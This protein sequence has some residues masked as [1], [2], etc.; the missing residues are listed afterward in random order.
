ML[1]I[2]RHFSF[3]CK[4]SR[5]CSACVR[6]LVLKRKIRQ[7]PRAVADLY[8]IGC[9]LQARG[10]RDPSVVWLASQTIKSQKVMYFLR[11]KTSQMVR[12]VRLIASCPGVVLSSCWRELVCGEL[13]M[14]PPARLKTV[15]YT[16]GF[17]LPLETRT[18]PV[19]IDTFSDWFPGR[20]SGC[21]R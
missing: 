4:D 19:L 9:G 2:C 10:P 14:P 18:W 12:F 1:L 3:S 7:V 13:A 11:Y 15:I 5:R 6:W 8:G 20:A 16:A 17:W 21:F